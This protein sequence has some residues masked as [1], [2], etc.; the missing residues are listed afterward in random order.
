M[1][2]SGWERVRVVHSDEYQLAGIRSYDDNEW[3]CRLP[4]EW[5][6]LEWKTFRSF[7]N[8]FRSLSEFSGL[9]STW[10]PK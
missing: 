8:D 6:L 4:N 7:F 5:L 9:K 10:C 3:F 2:A 1:K